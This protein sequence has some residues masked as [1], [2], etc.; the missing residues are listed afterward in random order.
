MGLFVAFDECS[1][2]IHDCDAHALC[3][4]DDVGYHCQCYAGYQNGPDNTCIG[5]LIPNCID[6]PTHV[7]T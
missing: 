2:G 7:C 1:A 5:N 6:S 4:N 3:I